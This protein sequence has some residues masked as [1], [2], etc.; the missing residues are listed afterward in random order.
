MVEKD[1]QDNFYKSLKVNKD[2]A[3][4]YQKERRLQM[5]NILKEN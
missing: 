1:F 3:F 5:I 2:I 4:G